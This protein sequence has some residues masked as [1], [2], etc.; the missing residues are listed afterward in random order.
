MKG[1]FDFTVQNFQPTINI[2]EKAIPAF[3]QKNPGVKIA[4]APVPFGEMATRVK[5]ATAAGTG[6]DGFHTYTGF[7][8]GTDAAN[9]MLP[10]TPQL[11]KRA[12]LDQL[13]FANV[14]TNA[15]WSRKP[16][17]FIMPFAVGVNGSMLLWNSALTGAA[18]VDPKR[19]ATL[20]DVVAGASRLTVRE[21]PDIKQ[22]GLLPV[23][24]TN[25]IMRWIVDQGGKFYDEKTY[26]WTWQTVQAERALQWILDLYD[27]HAVAWRQNPPGVS[28]PLGEQ[29]TATTIAGAFSISGYVTSHPEVF[30]KLVDQPLP[31]FV[32]GKTPNYYEHEYSGY[33]LTSLL[34]P[35]DGKAKIGAAFYRELLSPDWLI[36]RANEYSGAILAK[37][38]YSDPR[39]KDTTF[40]A[41]RA[42]LPEQVISK[43]L[44]M[45]MAVRPEEAQAEINKVVAGQTSIKGALSELQQQFQSK[46]DDA[47]RNMG[48]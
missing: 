7:W 32:P 5:A 10:L 39:F 14:L 4:Y 19:F 44:F 34:K 27:K 43:M 42:K 2:I 45:T 6:P 31:A 20:D 30:P 13:F 9:F 25:L 37:G 12:E 8:R 17:I 36:A 41:V 15:V 48:L 40:G 18:N 3:E 35:D 46:E 26:K 1:T 22:A 47:R 21:G 28:N 11:F 24:Q 38:V 23:S 29:R 33:A 16:E